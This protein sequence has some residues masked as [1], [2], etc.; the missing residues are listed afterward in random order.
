MQMWEQ[1]KDLAQEPRSSGEDRK[2]DH[3]GLCV[4]VGASAV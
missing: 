1:Q 2:S 3:I 4:M